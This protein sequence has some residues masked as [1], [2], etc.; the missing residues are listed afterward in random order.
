MHRKRMPGAGASAF[1]E[2]AGAAHDQGEDDRDD[3]E[4]MRDM[5]LTD[6]EDDQEMSIHEIQCEKAHIARLVNRIGGDVRRYVK[7]INYAEHWLSAPTS[8]PGEILHAVTDIYGRLR[9][10]VC[11]KSLPGFGIVP[12]L[13]F[14]CTTWMKTVWRVTSTSHRG[15][16]KFEG[17]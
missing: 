15:V 2:A 12:G 16:T 13:A 14:D 1:A 10:T 6:G 17:A 7:Q 8:P 9:V 11:V 5:E 4:H 3:D